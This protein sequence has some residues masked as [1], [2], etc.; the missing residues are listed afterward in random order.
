MMKI[1]KII[2]LI[3][4]SV[5]LFFSA[6]IAQHN[7]NCDSVPIQNKKGKIVGYT[8]STQA[9]KDNLFY[10]PKNKA[11]FDKK[12]SKK[13]KK[14][15]R[16]TTS[17]DGDEV[18]DQYS[19]PNYTIPLTGAGSLNYYGSGDAN[20]DGT[21]NFTD[22]STMLS[23]TSDRTD[24]NGD[25]L[26]NTTDKTLLYNYLTD[27]TPTL[28]GLWGF[29]TSA[30]KTSW[31]QKMLAI[32]LTNT[33][34]PGPSWDCN[35]YAMQLRINF[36]GIENIVNSGLNFS[37]YDTT[38]NARFNIPLYQVSTK[39]SSN[40]AHKINYTLVGEPGNVFSQGKFIEPQNDQIVTPGNQSLNQFAN[41][42]RYC[43][44]FDV[45]L[46]QYLSGFFDIINYTNINTTP[47]VAWQHPDLVINKPV[48]WTYIHP[49]GANPPDITIDPE[50]STDPSNTGQPN[51]A[52]W[53]STFYSDIDN[54]TG[55]VYDS[56]YWNYDIQRAW[57][58]VSDSS[59]LIDTT[60]S[61]HD[62]VN[63]PGLDPQ[64]ISVRDVTNPYFTYIPGGSIP[65]TSWLA[66]GV[67]NSQGGDNCG[68]YTITRALQS[69]TRGNDPDSCNHY[70]FTETYT[71]NI[72]DPTGNFTDTTF[73]APIEL[74]PLQFTYVPPSWV[75]NY[76]EDYTN[77]ANT[78]GY[79]TAINPAGTPVNISVADSSL[80]NPD[81]TACE[82]Y[83]FPYYRY[84]WASNDLIGSCQADS[85]YAL[86]YIDVQENLAPSLD[87]VPNDTI[88][89][90]GGCIT[91]LTCLP[92]SQG[93]DTISG[94][95]PTP[96]ALDNI[97][98]QG[99]DS[100]YIER[101]HW[102][103][104]ICDTPS[105]SGYQYITQM[106]MPGI[107]E[108]KQE[109][110]FTIYPNPTTGQ[111]HIKMN[112]S[113]QKP[114]IIKVTDLAGRTLEEILVNKGIDEIIYDASRLNPGIYL[115]NFGNETE[116]LLKVN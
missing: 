10:S 102:V 21:I 114:G 88:V 15:I 50:D 93:T 55:G 111:A 107:P 3:F 26:T 29:L 12:T 77:P 110:L 30:E 66:N 40:V 67:P 39:T 22:H 42:S 16:S 2:L 115:I 32:D 9:I 116:K 87:F 47:I 33:I 34:I 11:F 97:L 46:N 58:A 38:D 95:S 24:V 61:S 109:D 76:W 31:L 28:P 20:N 69:T 99:Y 85:I 62:T 43:R 75:I 49:G 36:A 56:T 65:Y 106:V 51:P 7:N 96:H 5:A 84:H 13:I 81:P 113:N 91:F 104:D 100:I 64:T 78:G 48:K 17:F 59:T 23:N 6:L 27:Q 89:P 98:Y 63:F 70:T 86:Q 60:Y 54:R 72:E 83:N 53:A 14:S 73:T 90:I 82:H 25:G 94:V 57:K 68:Y 108:Q 19:P 112:N 92:G 71:D 105:E 18:L 101:E 103:E 45:G 44:Y 52:S 37:I 74:N 79:A 41:I 4:I 35:Q 8:T 1:S 80:Q